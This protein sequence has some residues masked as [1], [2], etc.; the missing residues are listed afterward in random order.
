MAEETKQ[1]LLVEDNPGDAR[2][3][4]AIL[5]NNSPSPI[6]ITHVARLR[7]ALETLKKR[8]DFYVI[9]LDLSLPDSH[10][11]ETV[12]GVYHAAPDIPI[13]ILTG[14]EDEMTAN[15]A[16]II[17]AQDYL[18]KGQTDAQLL[19]RSI[20]YAADR[21]LFERTMR[22][23]EARYRL[24]AENSTDVIAVFDLIERRITYVSPSVKK[25]LGYSV[26]EVLNSPLEKIVRPQSQGESFI[27]IDTETTQESINQIDI[28]HPLYYYREF[29]HK[30]GHPVTVEINISYLFDDDGNVRSILAS[31]RDISERI[32]AEKA[33]A[34]TQE[35]FSK[36]FMISPVPTSITRL[37]DQII[38][39]IN[40][41]FTAH[42][43]Y[44]REEIIGH[45]G[46]ELGLTIE[47]E[48]KEGIL[49]N[50]MTSGSIREIDTPYRTKTGEIRMALL[51]LVT[52]E[53]S[54]ATC[55]M[56]MFYDIT[57][58]KEAED[59][60][61]EVKE[62]LAQRVKELEV[63]AQELA[64][65][66]DMVTTLQIC[67]ER[68]EAYPTIGKFVSLLC[69]DLDGALLIL[70]ENKKALVT[71]ATW[72]E[73]VLTQETHIPEYCWTYKQGK[74]YLSTDMDRE[75]LCKYVI[76]I[77]QPSAYRCLPITVHKQIIGLFFIGTR[78]GENEIGKNQENLII[79]TVEQI[80][81]AI[82][83][84]DLRFNLRDQAI[85]DPLTGL[86]NRLYMEETL[87]RELHREERI[88]NPLCIMMLDIDHFK[89][90]ND[91]YGHM[92]G[93]ALLRELGTM[94]RQYVRA[95]DVA[96][97]YGGEEFILI[98]P[99]TNGEAGFQRAEQLRERVNSITINHE[100]RT[101]G[102]ITVS[103]G[104]SVWPDNGHD[105]EQVID[106]ADEAMY[107]AKQEGRNRCVLAPPTI[108]KQ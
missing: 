82:S 57:E 94:L 23:S 69:P 55:F 89:K 103:V 102:N 41:S 62:Q 72:G 58:R 90:F 81:L 31:C 54:D 105:A 30:D 3:I 83:N 85:H 67:T 64:L 73:P 14:L 26:T 20:R 78:A 36:I 10:G 51:S 59:A 93:D 32:E 37:R 13:V 97:R 48:R 52:L 4:Q 76:P 88:Q 29:I 87:K 47:T 21:K 99:D 53:I 79:A 34:K 75:A 44:T 24:L 27:A 12:E 46:H 80:D 16:F 28:S 91:S 107:Q 106:A 74:T 95:S 40:E 56:T 77:H 49:A 9:L 86:F 84:L 1:L 2:L 108:I 65:L 104:V 60:L 61:Q 5:L 98:L 70:D 68:E 42:T 8:H 11:V 39:D 100:G 63:R 92:A 50:I 25:M 43:G 15:R 35:Q 18:I 66:T 17:G 96:C 45:T 7:E 19:W 33:L 22:E 71:Q 6:E 38:L 101:I